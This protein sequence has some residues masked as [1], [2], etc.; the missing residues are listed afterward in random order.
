MTKNIKVV[1]GIA[2]FALLMF[3]AVFAYNALSDRIKP[4]NGLPG[5]SDNS[6]E[7]AD[8]EKAPDFTVTDADRNSIRLSDMEGKPV[9]LNFWASW[10]PPCKLEMPD[11]EKLYQELGDDVQFMMVNLTDGQ[12]ETKD[13]AEAYVSGEGYTF[14]VFFDT[15]QQ[16]ASAYGIRS[17]PTTFFIDRDGYIVTGVQ[18]MLEE[19]ALRQG[20]DIIR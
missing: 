8:K 12:H 13:K 1:L 19:A 17:I 6:G 9:V 20:I 7:T 3:A 16:G 11:F 2:G 4:D 18:G 10:C 5:Q 14:P 15:K